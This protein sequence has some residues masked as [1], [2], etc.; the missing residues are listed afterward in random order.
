MEKKKV[1]INLIWR[2]AERAGAQIV[3]FIVSI[4]LA[5]LLSPSDYGTIALVNVFVAVLNVFVDSGLGS[6]LIQKKDADNLDF[7]TVFFT[8]V[9]FC[10]A[11]Y[12]AIYF[13]APLIAA[14]YEDESLIVLTR[15]LSLTV[16]ISGVRNVQQAYV[17]KNF[18]FKKFFFATLIGTI[19]SAVVGI[20]MAYS[21]YGVWALVAQQL[22][23]VLLGTIFLWISVRWRP[24]FKFS[25]S[26]LKGLFSFGWK[27]LASSFLDTVFSKIR[28]L[29]IGK[30]YSAEDLAYYNKGDM[31]P[32]VIANNINNSID[33]VLFPAMSDVQDKKESVKAMTRRAI[34]TS[35]FIMAPLMMG[36]AFTADN[37]VEILLT[38]KWLPCVFYLRIFCITFMFYPIHSAN[39]NAIKAMGK[40]D[41]FLKLEIIKKLVNLALLLSTIFISVEAMAYSLLAGSVCSQIINSWP[42]KKLLGYSYL[43]Q[44]KDILPSILL[45]VFMGGA[46]YL[47][48]FLNLHIVPTMIIQVVVGA[49]IYIAGAKIFKIDSLDFILSFVK[50]KKSK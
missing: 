22:L 5:R 29:L 2:F 48:N 14:F 8:N 46:V 36:L 41:V 13:C 49:I 12:V 1:L 17:S 10:T 7:S 15:V 26:R 9:V 44:L 20:W 45:A 4:I 43:E 11:L 6:A 27:L 38:A 50:K 21:G 47:F 32:S 40:S 24:Q 39:L 28:Q 23:N 30:I 16:V 37:F 19:G 42:N 31:F 18:M 25:F 3:S 35:V 34:K 33:S